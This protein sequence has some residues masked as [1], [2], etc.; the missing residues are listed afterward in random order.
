M[1][2]ILFYDEQE[3]DAR[4]YAQAFDMICTKL[5]L[6]LS[7]G[8]ISPSRHDYRMVYFLV[9]ERREKLFKPIIDSHAKVCRISIQRELLDYKGRSSSELRKEFRIR[10]IFTPFADID[11]NKTVEKMLIEEEA[12]QRQESLDGFA[13]I[14]GPLRLENNLTSMLGKAKETANANKRKYRR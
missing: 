8:Y 14:S 6:S 7:K 9:S 4:T 3:F 10:G 11:H 5:G 12:K 13:I 2:D 1:A